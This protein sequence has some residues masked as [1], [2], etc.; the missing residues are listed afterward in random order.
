LKDAA[1]KMGKLSGTGIRYAECK[2][3]GTADVRLMSQEEF[4]KGI[5]K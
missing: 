2:E 5:R 4:V 3:D 1:E